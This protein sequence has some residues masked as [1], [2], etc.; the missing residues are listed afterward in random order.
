MIKGLFFWA[1]LASMLYILH[2]SSQETIEMAK[3]WLWLFGIVLSLSWYSLLEMYIE[4]QDRKLKACEVKV[5]EKKW[6]LTKEQRDRK[7]ALARK[8]YKEASPE[9]KKQLGTRRGTKK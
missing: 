3:L 7:N 8:R 4:R 5:Q 1:T 9:R 2:E 6:G